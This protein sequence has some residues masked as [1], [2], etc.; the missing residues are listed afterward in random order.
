MT[1]IDA[2]GAAASRLVVS[3]LSIEVV[4]AYKGWN[5]ASM[6]PE[7]PRRSIASTSKKC[8]KR[9]FQRLLW[10]LSLGRSELSADTC[11]VQAIGSANLELQHKDGAMA[12]T[13]P[14]P[15]VM[16]WSWACQ[17]SYTPHQQ[18]PYLDP[19]GT[20]P[21]E[22]R[23]PFYESEDYLLG[24]FAPESHTLPSP[25]HFTDWRCGGTWIAN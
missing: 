2:K 11:N 13:E 14:P 20:L 21:E 4:T 17:N 10:L 5:S 19:H 18:G 16:F 6:I 22:L 12:G 7:S 9:L 15:S 25:F 1:L 3:L 8:I 24:D 23:L